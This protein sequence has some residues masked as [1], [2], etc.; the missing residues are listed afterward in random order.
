MA[1]RVLPG[2]ERFRALLQHGHDVALVAAPDGSITW[3]S[4]S[5][6]RLLG[7]A[8]DE[9][10]GQHVSGLV[11]PAD[12]PA[13]N[14]W[15][16]RI[17]GSGVERAFDGG[18]SAPLRLRHGDGSYTWCTV[19]AVR[20]RDADGRETG[21]SALV[22]DVD[23]LVLARLRAER[24]DAQLAAVV[25][26][27]VDPHVVYRAVR[28]E[29]GAVVDFEFLHVNR[30]AAEFEGRSPDS[31]AGLTILQVQPDAVE[32]L[33]DVDD[34]RA[35][36]QTGQPMVW[37]G[38][39]ASGYLTESGRPMRLDIRI[40][41]VGDDLVSY[42]FRDVTA[43]HLAAERL[44]AAHTLLRAVFDT[45]LEPH[46]VFRAVRDEAGEVVDFVYDDANEAAAA[47]EGYPR[48]VLVGASI[49]Q[50]Y[51]DPVEAA[52]DITDC[53]TV[54][55]TG[56]PLLANDV[57][58]NNYT[59]GEGLPV[60]T[61]IRIVPV[62]SERVSY[63]WRDV[64][65]RH[66]A[67]GAVEESEQRFRLLAENM[68]DVVTLVRDGIVEWVS[69]SVTAVAG[70][71]PEDIV[72]VTPLGL[73]HPDDLDRVIEA[74][75]PAVDALPRMRYRLRSKD[76]TY[77]WVDA[78]GRVT[79][80]PDGARLSV[81][82][83]RKVDNE[84]A[85]LDALESMARYDELTGLVNRH[86]VFRQ[87]DRVIS[88]PARTGTRVAMAFCDLDG[89]K[90]VN[91]SLGHQAG[92]ELLRA[93]A[94]RLER[95]VRSGDVVARLGGDE[96]LVVLNGVHDTDDAMRIAEK[97]R[98]EI[99][100]PTPLPGGTVTVSASIGVALVEPGESADDIIARADAAMYEAKRAGK[101]R[102]VTIAAGRGD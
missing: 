101:D 27:Q 51:R 12:L 46:A 92:D 15:R 2:D 59:D 49:R 64:S 68:S 63:A 4:D 16:E 14:A 3:A 66:R 88:G 87:I 89:F 98:S 38:V 21:I 19:S 18:T 30:A 95:A 93:V 73:I 42:A 13:A 8:P 78:E 43:Q 61:D 45:M 97:L 80:T 53:S 54:L 74:W 24:G 7:W 55:K 77:H 90:D 20:T 70:W 44:E 96:L 9:F 23:E 86:E 22:H 94:R 50:L 36:L 57:P 58:S 81:V 5:V 71:L 10:C 47:F 32:A 35:V 41:K 79:T 52:N 76:A 67:Q 91:D 34:C 6:T 26:S 69:P 82:A 31:L 75:L 25:D 83:T 60:F 84:V 85:A 33:D 29:A 17:L 72:G 28:D 99:R 40:S 100:L 11:H 62:D 1:D 37:N 48:E 102:V 65:E 56:R 39:E